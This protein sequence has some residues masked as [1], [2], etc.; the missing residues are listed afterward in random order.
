MRFQGCAPTDTPANLETIAVQAE[1]QMAE[2]TFEGEHLIYQQLWVVV[3]RQADHAA[4]K[5]TGVFWDH[6][7][8]MVFAFH[9]L[10]AYLNF[11]GEKLA[12]D[13]WNREREFFSK[14]PYQGFDGKLRMVLE[15][16]S[17][18]EPDWGRRPHSVVRTLKKLRDYIAHGKTEKFSYAI[19]HARDDVA[20]PRPTKLARMV[21]PTQY[22]SA[23]Q[24]V[25]Q[26]V[27][28]IHKAA[29]PRSQDIWFRH[30]PFDGIV[31]HA[32]GATAEI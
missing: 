2:T 25:E 24:D 22:S 21:S 5:R 16:I 4:V 15:L 9:T 11:V 19:K 1:K 23:I 10:E 29:L 13:I 31:F 3:Q 8:G 12:P 18:P 28:Q 32:S 30:D 26:F 20:M 17:M 27:R 14:K 6:L 7:V